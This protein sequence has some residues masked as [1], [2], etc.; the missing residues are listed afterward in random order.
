MKSRDVIELFQWSEKAWN[1]TYEDF[2]KEIKGQ[3]P[4]KHFIS[5]NNAAKKRFKK[6]FGDVKEYR[7]S[8]GGR[9]YQKY[10]DVK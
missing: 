2:V 7:V 5:G 4:G 9:H 8:M 10:K 1:N 3:F 6:L